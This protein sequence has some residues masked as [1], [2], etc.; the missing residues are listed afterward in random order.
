MPRGD[1]T[2]PA[3]AGPM[4]GRGMGRGGGA[5]SGMG[6]GSG[7]GRGRMGGSSLGAGG[8]CVCAACGKHFPHERGVPCM[9]RSCPECGAPLTRAG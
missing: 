8:D 9:Q 3:G 1:G 5:G 2:G 6:M 7:G 4:S